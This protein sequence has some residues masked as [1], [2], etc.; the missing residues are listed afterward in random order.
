MAVF[1]LCLWRLTLQPPVSQYIWRGLQLNITVGPP[2]STRTCS[3]SNWGPYNAYQACALS[4][5]VAA[6]SYETIFSGDTGNYNR[7]LYIR[8]RSTMVRV[9]EISR[10]DRSVPPDRM[11]LALKFS[12]RFYISAPGEHG[13]CPRL[14]SSLS[15]QAIYFWLIKT[16]R[17]SSFIIYCLPSSLFA[18]P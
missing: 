16:M 11:T 12:V 7:C 3:W 2:W 14:S 9:K 1:I 13:L 4:H 8:A 18:H 15:C 6:L 17:F 10:S 5:W